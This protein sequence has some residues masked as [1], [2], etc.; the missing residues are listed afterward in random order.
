[1]AA[2][3]EVEEEEEEKLY[4]VCK[5]TYD[6]EKVMIACDRW[7]FLFC[8]LLFL[9]LFSKGVEGVESVVRTREFALTPRTY[10]G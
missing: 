6:D 9:F 10:G 2:G 1:M 8:L 3:A 7:V 5:T 4:C